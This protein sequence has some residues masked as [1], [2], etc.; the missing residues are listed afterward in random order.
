M[1]SRIDF[2]YWNF[3]VLIGLVSGIVYTERWKPIELAQRYI[4]LSICYIVATWEDGSKSKK[5]LGNEH[6]WKK[7]L[8]VGK[9]AENVGRAWGNSLTYVDIIPGWPWLQQ[10]NY[11]FIYY[12]GHI[13]DGNCNKK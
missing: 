1:N 7:K 13:L 2:F 12:N 11:I 10:M 9:F 5:I 3:E 8:S 6:I 4:V